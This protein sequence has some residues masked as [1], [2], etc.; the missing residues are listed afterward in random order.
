MNKEQLIGAIENEVYSLME[1]QGLEEL[2]SVEVDLE[3]GEIKEI[4][5]N[6]DYGINTSLETD[7]EGNEIDLICDEIVA[8]STEN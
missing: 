6:G 3:D 5:V 7:L 4:I 2:E 1:N 8:R